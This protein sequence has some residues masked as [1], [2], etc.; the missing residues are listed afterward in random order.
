LRV[1]DQDLADVFVVREAVEGLEALG[2]V[3]GGEEVGEVA[4][5]LLVAVVVIAPDGRLLECA[6]HPLDLTIGPGVVGFGEP[7]LD[8]M[9]PVGAIE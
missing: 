7:M 6:V 8:A 4:S 2:Q 1:F 3:V 9:E 5:E